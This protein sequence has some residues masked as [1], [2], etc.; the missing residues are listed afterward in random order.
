LLIFRSPLAD[1][2]VESDHS[3]GQTAGKAGYPICEL[4]S[5]GSI[6]DMRDQAAE[7]MLHR[8]SLWYYREEQIQGRLLLGRFFDMQK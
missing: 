6:L 4:R 3:E 8:S 7:R 2:H 1:I 5:V